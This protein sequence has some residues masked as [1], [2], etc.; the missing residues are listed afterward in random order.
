MP[1]VP[2]PASGI[3]ATIQ[4]LQPGAIFEVPD[5]IYGLSAYLNIPPGATVKAAPGARPVF[6]STEGY[7]PSVGVGANATID[8]LWF[9]GA[10]AIGTTF[11]GIVPPSQSAQV[12]G[13][14]ATFQNCTFWGYF[15]CIEH[16]TEYGAP[17]TVR[18]NRFINCGGDSWSH[19][20]YITTQPTGDG[21]SFLDNIL[22]G[23]QGG[24][25]LHYWHGPTNQFVRG[26]FMADPWHG[27][28]VFSGSNHRCEKNITWIYRADRGYAPGVWYGGGSSGGTLTDNLFFG[29][30][31]SHTGGGPWLPPVTERNTFCNTVDSFGDPQTVWTQSQMEAELGITIAD[32]ND[33]VT[34]LRQSFF[35]TPQTVHDNQSLEGWFAVIKTLQSTWNT[36]TG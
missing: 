5:G 9:G 36:Y 28:M 25:Q 2:V 3:Q 26:N 16:G 7:A 33:K 32:I 10:M 15:E 23:A 21:D 18:N 11:G 17:A 20:V 27:P 4:A 22:I 24:Y 14:N 19:F 30:L 31:S 29:C 35:E 34:R 8:G 6:T 12:C 1:P 13:A